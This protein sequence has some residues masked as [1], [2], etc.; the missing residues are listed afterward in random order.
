M[1]DK[2]Q[3]VELETRFWQS[4]QDKDPL[5]AKAMIADECLVTGP[6]GTMKVDPDKYEQLTREGDWT[7]QKFDFSDIDV[8]FPSENIAVIAYKVHQTGELKGKPMDWNAADSS[9]WT[10]ESGTWK[11]ALHTET[12]L[13]D[14][15]AR[16]PEL[17]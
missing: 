12:I 5:T 9:V 17:A 11:C 3:I 14:T 13:Q 6:M 7:L 16:E 1:G 2:Q 4:M 15:K 8:I 10:R